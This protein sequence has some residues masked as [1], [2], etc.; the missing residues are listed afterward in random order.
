MAIGV[1]VSIWPS[2]KQSPRR[3]VTGK[4]ILV[5]IRT[6]TATCA[7]TT[8]NC[9]LSIVEDHRQSQSIKRHPGWKKRRDPE[10]DM[11]CPRPLQ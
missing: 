7:A 1:P 4:R 8:F 3:C 9:S 6:T 10:A 5:R 11:F 2:P